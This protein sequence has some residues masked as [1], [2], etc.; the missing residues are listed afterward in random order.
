[1]FLDD[2]V[3]LL[4]SVHCDL[5]WQSSVVFIFCKFWAIL[6]KCPCLPHLKSFSS[7]KLVA[8]TF[9]VLFWWSAEIAEFLSEFFQFFHSKDLFKSLRCSHLAPCLCLLCQGVLALPGIDDVFAF[10]TDVYKCMTSKQ[11]WICFLLASSLFTCLYIDCFIRHFHTEF[12]LLA[13]YNSGIA[14]LCP[15][16]SLSQVCRPL[17]NV[18]RNSSKRNLQNCSLGC[19]KVERVFIFSSLNVRIRC[20]AKRF[21]FICI[22]ASLFCFCVGLRLW[23]KSSLGLCGYFWADLASSWLCWVLLSHPSCAFEALPPVLP[24]PR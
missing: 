19:S 5:F 21:H 13:P 17:Y 1:M 3:C 18:F 10:C 2:V 20:P 24:A 9:T 6:L 7:V 23:S 8:K 11:M 15:C 14:I 4:W 16:L 12:A 22:N